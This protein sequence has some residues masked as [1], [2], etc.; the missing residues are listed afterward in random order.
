M[1][2]L[3]VLAGALQLTLRL[4]AEAPDTDGA[5]GFAGGSAT[6][7]MLIVT[8]TVSLAAPSLTL[9]VTV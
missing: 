3:P 9:T 6:S 5:A 7:V 8:G 1:A 4:V 2:G